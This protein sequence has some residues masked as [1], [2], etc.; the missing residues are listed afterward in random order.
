MTF[1]PTVRPPTGVPAAPLIMVSGPPKA[2]KSVVG[3]KLGLSERIDHCWVIDLGEGSADEY[4]ALGCYDVLEWGSSWSNLTD[5]V[6]W[7]VSQRPADGKLNAV[8]IDSGTEVW[9][10][11][12]DRATHRARGSRKNRAELAKDP[13]FEVDVSMNYWN[14]AANTWGGIVG[15]LKTAPHVVGVILVRADI[16][17]EV[18][19]GQPTKNKVVSLQAHK[20]LPATVTAHVEVRPDH[21]AWFTEVR[22]M[23]VQLPAKGLKLDAANPLGQV[24][25]MLAPDEGSF[26]ESV[27]V[28]PSDDERPREVV[29]TVTAEQ[30]ARL[31]EQMN[32]ITDAET[33]KQV[34][35]RF[36][37]TFGL[38]GDVPASRA[39]E[40]IDWVADEVAKANGITE[41]PD[42]A[43]AAA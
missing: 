12:K 10:G 15:P 26:G 5:S 1:T 2:G 40:A 18:V 24:L 13:D 4:G 16:V 7:C 17:A 6:K 20:S 35:W 9:E 36:K 29:Q 41:S 19:N 23:E 30:A 34:K 33:M 11:L 32:S 3:Y 38:P 43:E 8:I 27:A 31:L 14:D 39:A 42:G 28:K 25:D 22:S 21:S 37:E